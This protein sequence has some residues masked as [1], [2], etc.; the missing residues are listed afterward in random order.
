MKIQIII[1]FNGG[2]L[3]YGDLEN[4]GGSRSGTYRDCNKDDLCYKLMLDL[5]EKKEL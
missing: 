1:F 2:E 3:G 4:R 5:S